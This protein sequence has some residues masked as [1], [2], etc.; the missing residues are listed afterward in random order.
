MEDSQS[1]LFGIAK[2][3]LITHHGFSE[4]EATAAAHDCT[5]DF[6]AFCAIEK[7]EV[8]QQETLVKAL[9]QH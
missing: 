7:N 1:E 8:G 2:Q 3:H 9:N 6:L 5:E 4:A